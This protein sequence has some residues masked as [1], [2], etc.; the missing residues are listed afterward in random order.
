MPWDV[1]TFRNHFPFYSL[2]NDI[3]YLDNAA[4]TQKN[5]ET[6]DTLK[7]F[8]SHYNANVHRGAHYLSTKATELF[9]DA[10]NKIQNFIN[11]KNSYEIIFTKGT[12]EAINLVAFSY[13]EQFCKS[14][15]NIITTPIEHHSNFVPWQLAA[16]RKNLEL[17]VIPFNVNN[18]TLDLAALRKLVDN[19][20]KI[21]AITQ[22]S[23]VLGITTPIK[24]IIDFAHSKNIPVLI[25][26]AQS[27][28][29]MAIDVQQLDADFLALSAHKFYGPTGIG[30]LFGKEKWLNAM[31]P[32]QSGGEMIDL[33]TID[34]TTFN[35][36]PFKFEAG[37]PNFADAIAW[38]ATIDFISQFDKNQMFNYEEELWNYAYEKLSSLPYIKIFA[39]PE[40][41]HYGALS[42]VFND[43]H[44]YD[45]AS[46]LDELKIAVRVGHHCAQPLMN[47]LG[48]T[49]TI[50]ASFAPYN[51][52]DDID[53]LVEGLKTVYKFFNKN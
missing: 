18:Y 44:P 2:D 37:T 50:R 30:I 53:K 10:R 25:D 8:Y 19:N 35:E 42:F 24:E 15:D 47:L 33:V 17:R 52:K 13:I 43:I 45:A 3:V 40:Q 12:T 48:V 4:T 27:F 6:I 20:T 23:N 32:Y 9:E 29:H 14:G 51:N 46:V 7:F 31:P 1:N 34:K 38:G 39:Y 21:I 22:V 49:G 28:P 11:A 36:L 26:A 5:I 41:K 16:K